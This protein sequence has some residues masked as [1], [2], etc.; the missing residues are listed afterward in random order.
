[1]MQAGDFVNDIIISSMASATSMGIAGLLT[2]INEA[3]Y[4]DL[5]HEWWYPNVMDE[6]SIHG[7]YFFV[8]GDFNWHSWN[9]T[10]CMYFNQNFAD[11]VNLNKR[12]SDSYGY[13]NLYELVSAGQ[14]TY[15]KLFELSSSYYNDAN[16]DSTWDEFDTF[17][18]S[19]CCDCVEAFL[20][21]VE[22]RFIV[23]DEDDTP[24]FTVPD[25]F[26]TFF[27]AFNAFLNSD[28]TFFSDRPQY[29]SRWGEVEL[30]VFRDG[31]ALF[32]DN[33]LYSGNLALREMEDNYGIIPMPKY[34]EAQAE[35]CTYNHFSNN[36]C[37]SIPLNVKDIDVTGMIIEDLG[38]FSSIYIPDAYFEKTLDGKLARDDESW[39][40]LDLILSHYQYDLT[41]Y[42][43]FEGIQLTYNTLRLAVRNNSTAITSSIAKS[44]KIFQKMLNNVIDE[45]DANYTE[46]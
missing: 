21:G 28:S 41:N 23:K 26:Y 8:I 19:N 1:M 30:N 15:D 34:D 37:L 36:T 43:Y 9:T 40:M 3:P 4:I 25:N 45:I 2:P 24:Y 39:E 31:R 38:Y 27:P 46:K 35:Y 33:T 11:D 14:W 42:L 5:D 18:F 29:L 13:N 20:A 6:T 32:Y 10:F 12:L 44:V 22:I 17:G 16:G 7:N